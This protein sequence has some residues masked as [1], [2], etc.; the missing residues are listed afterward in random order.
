MKVYEDEQT[1]AFMDVAKDVDGHILVVPKK[2]VN[3][4]LD[5]DNETLSFVMNTVKKV[6]NYLVD[7]CGYESVNFLNASGISAGQSVP[8]FHIH[9]IP[10]ITNDGLETW[11]KLPGTIYEIE[12]VYQKIM[13]R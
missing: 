2:H 12:E 1:L 7:E 9:I 4:I 11:P 13:K 10:R 6:S 8:H 3:N 5:C